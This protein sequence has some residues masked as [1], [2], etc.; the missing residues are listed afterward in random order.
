MYSRQKTQSIQD[1][2]Q[3]FLALYDDV[4]FVSYD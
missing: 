2:V 4:M 3:A 1:L